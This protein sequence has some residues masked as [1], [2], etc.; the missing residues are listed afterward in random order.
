MGLLDIFKPTP[1][2]SPD[3]VRELIKNKKPDEYCLLDVRQPVEYE[4]GHLPGARLIPVSELSKKLGELDHNKPTIAYCRSGSR[5]RSATGI[6]LG[7]GFKN[8]LNMEGGISLYNGIVAAGSP[9]AG[10]FCFPE[11]LNT[12]ELAAVAWF[13]EN[14]TIQFLKGVK[15]IEFPAI[16][17]ELIEIKHS[18]KN[19]L[20]KL[21]SDLTGKAPAPDFPLSVLGVPAEDIMV[22]C[23][24]VSSALE[25]ARGKKIYDILEL[26]ISL[27][28]NTY[29]LYLKLGRSVKPD[30][31][32]RLFTIL[33]GEEQHYIEQLSS[34]F[35]KTFKSSNGQ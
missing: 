26:L 4:K 33:S 3:E 31:A 34:A 1:S 13:L 14:G 24:K 20:R 10:M 32:R 21:Y 7:S 11:S 5:S 18:H 35:E 19:R 30:E 27:E 8:V 16:V 15:D 29:D 12:G 25:W 9:E 17:Q 22:G 28:A 23:V 2:I 6:L